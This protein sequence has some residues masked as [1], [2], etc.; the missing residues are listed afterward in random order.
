MD[1]RTLDWTG[2]I[3]FSIYLPPPPPGQRRSSDCWSDRRLHQAQTV[4]CWPDHWTC[5]EEG[6]G[7]KPNIF[8][9][10]KDLR[11]INDLAT[12][13]SIWII[14]WWMF[15]T[16]ESVFVRPRLGSELH[17]PESQKKIIWHFYKG[18]ARFILHSMSISTI[19]KYIIYCNHT[20]LSTFKG[21]LL[22]SQLIE[23]KMYLTAKFP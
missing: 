7:V 14:A 10:R 4:S 8:R 3:I 9:E 15:G 16:G 13:L 23:I 18:D 21:A 19:N 17:S 5:G 11:I 12:L 6:G 2:G 20:I 22:L 1:W